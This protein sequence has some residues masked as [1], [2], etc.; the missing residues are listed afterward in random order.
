MEAC[1]AL[2]AARATADCGGLAVPAAWRGARAG[3]V[4]TV[5]GGGAGAVDG[6]SADRGVGA[7]ASSSDRGSRRGLTD[8]PGPSVRRADGGSPEPDAALLGAASDGDS[9]ATGASRETTGI[10]CC[11]CARPEVRGRGAS[12]ALACGEPVCARTG[13]G[14]GAG[15]GSFRGVRVAAVE[16]PAT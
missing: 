14:T 16:R 2:A 10:A 13:A 11:E 7:G 6:A 5:P 3:N 15:A 4:S 12:V 9:W 1:V 8:G